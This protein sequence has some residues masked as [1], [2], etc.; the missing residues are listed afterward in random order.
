M[1][2]AIMDEME[3]PFGPAFYLST[4][5]RELDAAVA[6]RR[7]YHEGSPY[8]GRRIH[9]ETDTCARCGLIRRQHHANGPCPFVED[10]DR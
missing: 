10:A 7:T 4:L 2:A 1:L 6:D 3:C 9:A 8:R 5:E